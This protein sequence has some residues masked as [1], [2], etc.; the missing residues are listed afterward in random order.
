[1]SRCLPGML[2]AVSSRQTTTADPRATGWRARCL[3][4]CVRCMADCFPPWVQNETTHVIDRSAWVI[5]AFDSAP[6]ADALPDMPLVPTQTHPHDT[7]VGCAQ[8]WHW[9]CDCIVFMYLAQ[10]AGK[11]SAGFKGMGCKPLPGVHQ[12]PALVHPWDATL[13]YVPSVVAPHHD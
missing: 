6:I 8:G 2:E 3:Q 7:M 12:K 5:T 4:R 9:G 1:V 13:N 11:A 10:F